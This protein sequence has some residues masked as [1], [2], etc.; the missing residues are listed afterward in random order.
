[1]NKRPRVWVTR[2]APGC[3]KSAQR[4][5]KLG[6]DAFAA[7]VQKLVPTK[8]KMPPGAERASG[9]IFTSPNAVQFTVEAGISR[10]LPAFCVGPSTAEAAR[11][12]GFNSLVTGKGGA[13]E[14]SSLM[15]EMTA[16]PQ[17]LL[18][19]A[20][21]AGD[22]F[23]PVAEVQ[24]LRWE[25][26]GPAP[27]ALEPRIDEEIRAGLI[28]GILVYSARGAAFLRSHL[29]HAAA[30]TLHVFAISDAAAEPL[31]TC[32]WLE[33]HIAETP[34]EDSLITSLIGEFR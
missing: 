20:N 15:S 18:H 25:L 6:F 21:A 31:R 24:I 26:Y 14:L 28:D 12:A 2:S 1:M 4:L 16:L 5:Q 29:D 32:G 10:R 7:P 34:G 8:R 13:L 27:C 22:P 3:E 11:G 19:P 30:G 33:L 23:P 17:R 9:I